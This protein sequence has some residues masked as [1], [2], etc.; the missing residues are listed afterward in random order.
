MSNK[1]FVWENTRQ[2]TLPGLLAAVFIP[3]AIAFA[4]FHG[5]APALVRSG[6]PSVYA[7][8][9]V[10]AVAL[11]GFDIFALALLSREAR[12][13]GIG[14]SKRL[15]LERI[16][17]RM[18]LISIGVLIAGIALSF[19][20]KFLVPP[21]MRV[22]GLTVPSYTPFFLDPNAVVS[23]ATA[24]TLA[25]GVILKG[26]FG[27]LGLQAGVLI[28]NISAE[29]LYFRAWMLPKLSRFGRASWIVNGVLFALYH[30]F[31]FWLFPQLLVAS[32]GIAFVVWKTRSIWPA[33]AGHL[34]GNFLLGVL[35]MLA[36]VLGAQ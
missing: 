34:V 12:S 26:N 2:L 4:G 3:S 20:A 11:A 32:L 19:G 1:P 21:F 35:G 36:L 33:I 8:A 23:P 18:W 30:T 5:V 6:V 14:L 25:P 9:I 15:C 17:A 29:E 28:L 10:A 16:P 27:I 31:Q 7:W 24:A 13:L 22:F